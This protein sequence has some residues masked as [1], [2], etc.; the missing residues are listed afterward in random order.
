MSRA[1]YRRWSRSGLAKWTAS[2][3][4]ALLCFRRWGDR[5]SRWQWFWAGRGAAVWICVAGRCGLGSR[6]GCRGG[7]VVAQHAA[8]GP[9][10]EDGGL[11][12]SSVCAALP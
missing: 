7:G 10:P 1:D 2:R 9:D 12:S 11:L 5:G 4:F 8:G 3:W 6:S